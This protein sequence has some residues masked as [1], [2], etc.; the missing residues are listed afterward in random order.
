MSATVGDVLAL[1]ERVAPAEL[2]EVGQRR[3]AGGSRIAGEY[4]AVRAGIA[5]R[6]SRGASLGA[7]LIVT[8]HP[9]LFRGRNLCSDDP[10]GRLLCA[11]IGRCAIAMH[12]NFDNAT[13]A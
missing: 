9:I 10:E 1:L 2:A 13:P 4:G 8:H 5:R 12:T 3:P 11:L 6:C 7:E